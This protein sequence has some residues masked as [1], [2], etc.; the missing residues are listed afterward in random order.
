M[1]IDGIKL[2]DAQTGHHSLNFLPP[3][4][5][6]ER[7]EIIKGPAA[8]VFGQN[9][10]TGAVNIVTKKELTTGGTAEIGGGSYGQLQG[11]LSLS[12]REENGGI[13]THFSRISS[14]GYR[15][16]S[17]FKNTTAFIKVSLAEA[18]KVP[19]EVLVFFFRKEI[20]RQRFL[21]LS[22][23]QRPI[24]RDGSKPH[25]GSIQN[26]K[27]ELGFKTQCVLE[28]GTRSLLVSTSAT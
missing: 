6:I 13:F 20:W 5:T 18:Q 22:R 26:S 1:L 23:R 14:D 19:L 28:K 9:A 3:L 2:D 16:N 24:R 8:R 12:K 25:C 27:R 17:D 15:Y 4:E 10:L 21:R 7:I 11:S